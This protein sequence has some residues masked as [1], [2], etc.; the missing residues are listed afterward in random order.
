MIQVY[1]IKTKK[2]NVDPEIW[3]ESLAD[4][5]REDIRTRHSDGLYV[6]NVRQQASRNDVRGI[7]SAR[8]F[9]TDGMLYQTM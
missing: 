3:F 8:G 6:Y 2:E 4:D 1:K 5:K 9:V 7:F